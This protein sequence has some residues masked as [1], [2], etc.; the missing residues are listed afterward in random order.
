MDKKFGYLRRKL[1]LKRVRD[2]DKKFLLIMIDALGYNTLM[3]VKGH[4]PFLSKLIRNYNL[5]P[6]NVGIPST[7][8]YVQA[9]LFYNYDEIIPGFR[10]YDKKKR[11]RITVGSMEGA[12]YIEERL[13][14][15]GRGILFEGSSLGNIFAA[16]A[17]RTLFTLTG[18]QANSSVTNFRDVLAI[19]FLNPFSFFRVAYFSVKEFFVEVYE[20][21]RDNFK[22][23]KGEFVNFSM[24]YPYF[25]FFRLGIN[26]FTRE[27]LTEAAIL[28][29]KRKVTRIGMT[30]HGYDWVSHYRKPKSKSSLLVL[31]EIDKKLEW[32]YKTARKEGYDFYVYSDHDIVDALPFDKLYNQSLGEFITRIKDGKREVRDSMRDYLVYK[33]KYLHENFSLPLRAASG[34]LLKFFKIHNQKE[35]IKEIEVRNSSCISHVYFSNFKDRLPLEDI[36]KYYPGMVDKLVKHEGVGIVVCKG[37]DGMNVFG[38]LSKYG[39]VVQLK[40]WLEK[41]YNMEY[42]GD[43][44]IMGAIKNGKIVSFEDFH[45]GTHDG[46]GLDQ[47]K[48]FFV[49]KKRYD[50]SKSDDAK[51]LHSIFKAYQ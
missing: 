27:V 47:H 24:F 43:L 38:D 17:K 29:M 11:K 41:V 3:D 51:V 40:R 7:T 48:G 14:T 30:F 2:Q 50:F 9:G 33:L 31:R 22:K 44:F 1:G 35:K 46:F 18:M 6:Y 10:V 21:L 12:S 16:G 26:A 32:L 23:K 5:T 42:F 37:K 4:M 15:R 8:P 39:N 25:P 20:N 13:K 36:E 19:V 34:F 49:S 45:L 28:E